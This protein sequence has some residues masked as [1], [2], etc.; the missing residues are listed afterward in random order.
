[1]KQRIYPAEVQQ[2]IERRL[3]EADTAMGRRVTDALAALG[4]NALGVYEVVC[5]SLKEIKR[6]PRGEKP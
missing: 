1:M 4:W 2:V 6:K 3:A 5:E